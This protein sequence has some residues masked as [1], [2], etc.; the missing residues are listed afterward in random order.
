M[1]DDETTQDR[2]VKQRT[3]STRRKAR[4]FRIL[5]DETTYV[6]C[7]RCP[8]YAA[9]RYR[10]PSALY[11]YIMIERQHLDEARHIHRDIGGRRA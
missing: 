7:I 10:S 9:A 2:G 1:F 3:S 8:S 11:T 4:R 5:D 6:G